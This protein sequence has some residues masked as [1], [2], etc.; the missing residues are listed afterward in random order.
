MPPELN[1]NTI[2]VLEGE[3]VVLKKKRG[4]KPGSISKKKLIATGVP[5]KIGKKLGKKRGRKPKH[6]KEKMLRQAAILKMRQEKE[7]MELHKKIIFKHE[8]TIKII[9]EETAKDNSEQMITKSQKIADLESK[10]QQEADEMQSLLKEKNWYQKY[11]N[12]IASEELEK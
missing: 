12:K 6:I 4:R 10:L 1:S 2:L 11:A 9:N 7:K 3:E 5:L 8:K